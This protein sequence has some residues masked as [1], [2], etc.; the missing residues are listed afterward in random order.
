MMMMTMM[1]MVE[2]MMMMM[3]RR[4]REKGESMAGSTRSVYELKLLK[5]RRARVEEQAAGQASR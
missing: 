1:M 4:R 2:V 5:C 3:R